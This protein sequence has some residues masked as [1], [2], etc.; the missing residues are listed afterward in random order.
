MKA[1]LIDSENKTI[2]ETSV[3]SW[4]DIAPAIGADLFTTIT[5]ENNDTLYV[6]D[7]GLLKPQENFFLYAGYDQPLAGNG[8]VLGTTGEGESTDPKNSIEFIRS[9]VRFMTRREA[10]EW[11]IKHNQ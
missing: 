11:A 1:Y 6:D 10:Y 2:S 9:K 7:E 4:K 5:I 3:D 8:L